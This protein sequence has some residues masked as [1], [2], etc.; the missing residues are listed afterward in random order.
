MSPAQVEERMSGFVDKRFDVLVATTIIESGLDIPAANTLIV[1]KADRFGLAQLY[2]IRGRVGRAKTRAYAYLTTTPDKAVTEAAEKRLHVLS[3]L[4]T[5]GA[6]FQL[7]SHDLDQRG[8]GNLL[9][10]EQSGHIKE[11]G[12][13]L[14]QSMLEEAILEARAAAAGMKPPEEAFSPQISLELPIL[15]PEAYVPDLN[16]RMALYRRLNELEDRGAID[17]FAAEVID[18]FGP[19]PGEFANLLSVIEIKQQC[20]KANVA[21]LEA[22]AKGALITLRDDRFANPEGLMAWMERLGARAKLRPDQKLFVAADWAG[23]AARVKGSLQVATSLAK[24]AGGVVPVK[25]EAAAKPGAGAG[26]NARSLPARPGVFKS[27]IR[28]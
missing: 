5:L 12:F 28:R 23:E 24:L 6:G 10:D 7:A 13:E 20:L 8:A 22:G 26:A 15:I 3:V 19:L 27:K 11:I 1:H 21:R 25:A 9:G 17:G 2:Q 16:V 14:Y 18:R 4:D